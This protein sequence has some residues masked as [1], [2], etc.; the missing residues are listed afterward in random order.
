MAGPRKMVGDC[1]DARQPCLNKG[2][3]RVHRRLDHGFGLGR[4]GG[5]AVAAENHGAE[6]EERPL[7]EARRHRHVPLQ[8]ERRNG[9]QGGGGGREPYPR[10]ACA[11]HARTHG[12]R[13]GQEPHHAPRPDSGQPDVGNLRQAQQGQKD[14]RGL[15]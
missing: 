5:A 11:V 13:R 10:R 4:D 2:T 9:G 8:G 3:V 7:G 12:D 15:R 1:R 14:H 6:Y